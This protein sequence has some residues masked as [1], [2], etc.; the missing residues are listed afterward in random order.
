M[1]DVC[2]RNRI[3]RSRRKERSHSGPIGFLM[4]SIGITLFILCPGALADEVT[5]TN[6]DVI[7]GEILTLEGGK[8][9]VKTPYNAE[10][11]LDWAAVKSVKSDAPVELVNLRVSLRGP[12]PSVELEPVA[13]VAAPVAESRVGLHGID[14]EVRV[15]ARDSLATG[16]TVSGPALIT[17]RVS[18]TFLAPG[19][20]AR[21]DTWGNLLLRRLK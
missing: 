13:D 18:T 19:W 4:A 20:E 17:E 12:L 1:M 21:A 11:E 10:L 3:R 14:A 7:T 15:L 9:K 8:L 6:G 16:R 5:M 2:G